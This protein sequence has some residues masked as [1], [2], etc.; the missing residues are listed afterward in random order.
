M[1]NDYKHNH[2]VPEW[3][4]KNFLP[5]SGTSGEL[6]Y[7]KLKP[8]EYRDAKGG[9]HI[10][11]PLKKWHASR[12]FAE[13]DL[14]TT[15]LGGIQSRDIERLFFGTIDTKGKEAVDHFANYQYPDWSP[16]PVHHLLAYLSTQ[17][18]RTPK[19]LDW[20]STQFKLENTNNALRQMLGLKDVFCATWVECVWQICD[21]DNSEI[22]FIIS[23]HPV[24]IY[25]RV[26]GPR[27]R[28]CRGSNDP[29]IRLAGSHTVFPLTL[30]KVL[31]LTNMTWVMNPYQK[32]TNPRP[33]PGLYRS[34]V[35]NFHNFHINRHFSE[36]EVREI[37][38][39]IK[40]RAYNYIAAGKE[41]WLY[42][43]KFVSKS[44]WNTYG[45]GILLMPDPRSANYGGEV[46]AG[47]KDGSGFAV[48]AY[49][50]KPGD[51]KFGKDDLPTDLSTSPLYRF[52]GD[53]ARKFGPNRRGV[54]LSAGTVEDEVDN[55]GLHEYHLSLGIKRRPK[56]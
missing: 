43:E 28:W 42:P 19:G 18:L 40:S 50:R 37:N 53:F 21:A 54:T 15:T 9:V 11:K 4:Q 27:N 31:I 47:Y 51:P 12:C 25:N 48:D 41:E 49:G 7:L 33:N 8:D 46:Y 23:D 3:Y 35:F 36:Q 20:L 55:D 38:C 29:D 2:Y 39:I 44:D 30:N 22:K 56:K 13:D 5:D 17:K 1:D 14:Y 6:Y 10:A 16:E 32:A 34:T 26:L 45:D 52:K 24:T